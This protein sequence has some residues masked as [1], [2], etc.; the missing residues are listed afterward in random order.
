M[1]AFE[2]EREM[3]LK[4]QAGDEEALMW[5][6]D[7]Y[8]PLCVNISQMYKGKGLEYWEIVSCVKD[9]FLKQ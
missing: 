9:G 2:E 6:W 8:Q 1:S 3:V 5:L 4:A 7:K